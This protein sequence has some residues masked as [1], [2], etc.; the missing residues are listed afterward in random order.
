MRRVDSHGVVPRTT[1]IIAM[2]QFAPV[3]ENIRPN[4]EELP[5]PLQ[6]G[7]PG[8]RPHKTKQLRGNLQ[9]LVDD[10][11]SRLV[12]DN[13]SRLADSND[14]VPD[15]SR[16]P[17]RQ[18]YAGAKPIRVPVDNLSALA[19]D[20]DAAGRAAQGRVTERAAVLPAAADRTA[21]GTLVA[22]FGALGLVYGEAAVVWVHGGDGTRRMS[23]TGY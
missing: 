10:N 22:C 1:G 19:S 20:G 6:L 9:R 21:A 13:A 15:I 5:S 18:I 23:F 4:L 8:Q 2:S 11:A 16:F 14:G 12:D 17:G 3:S 7:L